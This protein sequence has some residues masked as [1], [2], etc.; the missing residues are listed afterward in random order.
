M[1]L[2]HYI[3][4]EQG[5]HLQMSKEQQ[6]ATALRCLNHHD[7]NGQKSTN[8]G[9]CVLNGYG[10]K[11]NGE[12]IA[13]NYAGWARIYVQA[14][15]TIPAKYYESFQRELASDNTAY[16]EALQEDCEVYGLKIEEL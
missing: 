2:A 14:G 1:S 5:V 11:A 7:C 16:A 8:C 12:P 6:T 10:D 4:T 3:I 15:K 9:A 13:P